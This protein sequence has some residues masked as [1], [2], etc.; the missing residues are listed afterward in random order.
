ML[1]TLFLSFSRKLRPKTFHEID[2]KE[3]NGGRRK[4]DFVEFVKKKGNEK[5]AAK[6]EL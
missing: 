5:A 2:S 3:Y 4:M 6:D 1:L